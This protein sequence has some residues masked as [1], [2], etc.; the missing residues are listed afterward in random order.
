[1]IRDDNDYLIKAMH[2]YENRAAISF[3]EFKE[4]LYRII[5]IR[6]FITKYQAGEEINVRGMLNNFVVLFNVF[7]S[8]AFDLIKYK[9]PK[10]QYP[11]AF[12]FLVQ[13]NRL[14]E[15]EMILLDQVIVQ[16]LREL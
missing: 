13:L 11:V 8:G 7:G 10:S 3:D 2:V 1:M 15:S 6:K 5:T 14:P 16:K 4:D 12:A 9:L